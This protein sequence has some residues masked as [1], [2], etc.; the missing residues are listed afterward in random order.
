M[1]EEVNGV[2]IHFD[3]TLQLCRIDGELMVFRTDGI[4][5]NSFNQEVSLSGM[6]I[7]MI[8]HSHI[9]LLRQGRCDFLLVDGIAGKGI[10]LDA[11]EFVGRNIGVLDRGE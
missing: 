5:E 7:V 4:W 1:I 8:V 11:C 10:V 2:C 3:I 9:L 6:H